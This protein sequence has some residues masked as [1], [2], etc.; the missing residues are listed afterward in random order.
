M[1]EQ[2]VVEYLRSRAQVEPPPDLTHSVMTAIDAAPAARAWFSA[3]LP[4]FAAAGAVVVVA[5]LA[6]LIGPGRNVGPAPT[7][8]RSPSGAATIA[9]AE[10]LEAAVTAA[11]D[12][13]AASDG[14]RG[15]HLY[16]IEHY[17]ASATWF[18]W[19]PNGDQVVVE[20]QDIDVSAPWWTDPSGQPL[21]VGERVATTIS[22]VAAGSYHVAREEGW[23]A[24]LEVPRGPL[25]YAIGILSGEIPAIGGLAPNADVVVSRHE[26]QDGGETWVL[27][28]DLD[29]E[30]ATADWRIDAEGRLVSYAI[31]GDGVAMEPGI[32]LGTV[33]N[34]AVIEFTPLD[35]P[36]PIPQPDLDAA[37][38]P[39]AFG[40]PDEF[41]LSEAQPEAQINYHAYV[42]DVLD[43]LQAYHW[44]RDAIDWEAARSAALDDLPEEPDAAQAHQRIRDAIAT[45]DSFNTVFVRPDDVPPHGEHVGGDRAVPAGD[46]LEGVGYVRLPSIGAAGE[47]ALREYLAAARGAMEA[48][49]APGGAC[50]WIVDLRDYDSG[51]WGPSI[52]ALGGLLG[53]GR[54]VTFSSGAGEWW[55]EVAGDG[56]V[57]AAGFDAADVPVDSPFIQV[58]DADPDAS[59]A[60]AAE[61]PY[62][63]SATD[64]PVAVLVSNRTARGGEQT[65]AAFLGR[66]ATRVF[67]GPTAGMPIVSPNYEL[68]D[69]A[70]LRV[71]TWVPVDRDGTRHTENIVPDEVVGDTRALGSDAVLDAAVDWLEGQA[72]CS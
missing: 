36:Q 29:G 6:L 27:E 15:T 52:F 57:T 32:D 37:P 21:T 59:D 14:V 58:P 24:P 39:S 3:Y 33:S 70:V 26:L 42:E 18:D 53:D 25:T 22:V 40:L 55:L 61:P 13:L 60:V 20:R 63:P 4:A 30:T 44:N 9:S 56:V 45:F 38:D 34:R 50:G 19:R 11:V 69:G 35:E 67:G 28:I 49:D 54:V 72:G 5:L 48:A 66:P 46:R 47:D 51:A 71:P 62:R 65:V 43:A 17:L 2:R 16:S 68:I 64:A 1:N 7:P 23:L 8:V 12:A 31:R 41:P 10:E